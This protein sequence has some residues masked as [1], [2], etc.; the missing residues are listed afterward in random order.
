MRRSNVSTPCG[1]V[2]MLD[3]RVVLEV[4]TELTKLGSGGQLQRKGKL[5]SIG[6]SFGPTDSKHCFH[7]AGLISTAETSFNLYRELYSIGGIFIM[8]MLI[9]VTLNAYGMYS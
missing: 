5:R 8:K 7:T 6:R 2:T 1:S 4:T 3:Q 9:N